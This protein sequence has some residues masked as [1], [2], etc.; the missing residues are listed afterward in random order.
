M[1]ISFHSVDQ[2]SLIQFATAR[3]TESEQYLKIEQS[4]VIRGTSSPDIL[5]EPAKFMTMYRDELLT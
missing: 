5:L 1:I 4:G 2:S 3:Q